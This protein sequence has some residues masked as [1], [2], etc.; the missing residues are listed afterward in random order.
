VIELDRAVEMRQGQIE[1]SCFEFL[2][3]A[4]KV[5]DRQA[6]VSLGVRCRDVQ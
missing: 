5:I 3:A 1:I 4:I 6:A 2:C